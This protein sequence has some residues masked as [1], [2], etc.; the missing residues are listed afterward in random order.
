MTSTQYIFGKPEH[1]DG[2]GNVH[3]VKLKNYDEF[4]NCSNYLYIGKDHF[5][6]EVLDYP[7]LQL[8]IFAFKDQSVIE[9]LEKLFALVLQTEV[10]AFVRDDV[11]IA[12]KTPVGGVID[13]FNYDLLRRTIMR[14]N[15]MF[16]QK[17]YKDKVVQA[18]MHKV[19]EARA[20]N[21]SKLEFEDKISTVSVFS[22]KHYWDLEEYT[23]YQL[24][25]DFCRISKFKNFDLTVTARSLG[26]DQKIEHFAEN[27]DMFKNPYDI[28]SFTK[29]KDTANK[30][31]KSMK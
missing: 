23:I 29:S 5:N 17:V 10:Q 19:F 16:E 3:P 1:I 13:N 8:L 11:E 12:F 2:L 24:E 21:S 26:S 4:I 18:Y 9:D 25:V 31:D 27:V 20:K 14:Q 22:G 7:L 28:S 15:L 6:D 30:L